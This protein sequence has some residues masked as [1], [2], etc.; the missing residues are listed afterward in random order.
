VE[1]DIDITNYR[2]SE[3][4]TRPGEG[5]REVQKQDK[6]TNAQHDTPGSPSSKTETIRPKVIYRHSCSDSHETASKI[7]INIT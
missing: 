1:N 7:Y 4:R 2:L 3:G 5:G 6:I